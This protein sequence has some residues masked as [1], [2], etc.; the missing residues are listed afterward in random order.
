MSN[1]RDFRYGGKDRHV[2]VVKEDS[3]SILALDLTKLDESE[4]DEVM[5][6]F[7]E[8]EVPDFSVKENHLNEKGE[9]PSWTKA[10][11]QFT[12]AKIDVEPED[13]PKENN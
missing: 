5:R 3:K 11:K 7:D 1:V 13:S 6:L 4:T 12:V 2:L 9:K 8:R 10:W